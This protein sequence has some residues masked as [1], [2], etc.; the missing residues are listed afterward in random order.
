MK[1]L[2]VF[3]LLVELM[4][5]GKS[6]LFDELSESEP[7][8]VDKIVAELENKTG[9]TYGRDF[10]RWLDWYLKQRKFGTHDEKEN[11]KELYEFKLKAD[12]FSP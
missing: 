10:D 2:T 3:Q 11:L 4:Y 5:L 12:R 7:F 8:D 6:G 1:N 9:H